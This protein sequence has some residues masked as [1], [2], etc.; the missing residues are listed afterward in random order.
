MKIAILGSG[1]REHALAVQIS[2][3]KKL[4]KIYCI[5]GN[6]GTDSI[7]KNVN[8]EL[9]NFDEIYRFIKNEKIDLVIVGPEK[10]LVDGIVDYLNEKKI[11]VGLSFSSKTSIKTITKKSKNKNINCL[12]LDK[13]FLTKSKVLNI[14]KEKLHYRLSGICIHS[15]GLHGGHYYAMC[16]NYKTNNFSHHFVISLVSPL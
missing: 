12:I 10:P 1:G 16:K 11:K 14:N 3:S 7:G 2:K 13:Y 8:L 5:P 4:D 15:G 6:A 9:D